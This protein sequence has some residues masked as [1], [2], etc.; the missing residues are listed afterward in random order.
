MQVTS[1]ALHK[2]EMA[3]FKKQRARLQLHG[4]CTQQQ[5]SAERHVG[6]K[7]IDDI[8]HFDK[9]PTVS[10]ENKRSSAQGEIIRTKQRIQINHPL[11]MQITSPY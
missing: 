11:E 7:L 10:W 6:T 3:T 9:Q 5:D 2:E 4:R 1:A 8:L